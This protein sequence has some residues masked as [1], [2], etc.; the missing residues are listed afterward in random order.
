MVI[1]QKTTLSPMF[2]MFPLY[3]SIYAAE[4]G[5]EPSCFLAFG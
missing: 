4:Q 5:S 3:M 2:E 1:E